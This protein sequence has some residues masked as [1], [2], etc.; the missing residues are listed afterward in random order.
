M[1]KNRSMM[2]IL[3]L[4]V[5]MFAQHASAAPANDNCLMF[6]AANLAKGAGNFYV[7]CTFAHK[8]VE[9]HKGDVLEYDIYLSDK[10]PIPGGGIDFETDRG[11]SLRD[12]KA[13]DQNQL[14]AHGDAKLKAAVGQ[15][16]HRKIALDPL[17]GQ[18]AVK[19]NVN[20]EGDKLGAYVQFVDHVIVRR[21]DGTTINVYDGG[22]L[23][24]KIDIP[25]R[26][27]YSRYFTLR[28]VDRSKF[29]DPQVAV[30]FI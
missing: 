30:S 2:T 9:L 13:V 10:N 18:S 12:S 19:W 29:S 7:Y 17:A 20:F 8:R 4:A 28:A 21:A 15:W 6:A 24:A 25:S 16:L 5:A 11:Q 22:A 23:P 27:G 26:E 14:R 1:T 3:L